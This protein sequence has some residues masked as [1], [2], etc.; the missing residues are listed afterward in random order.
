[1]TFYFF[2]PGKC[3][4]LKAKPGAVDQRLLTEKYLNHPSDCCIGQCQYFFD[5]L[6]I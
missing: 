1:M 6:L 2:T 5:L 3:C 4:A